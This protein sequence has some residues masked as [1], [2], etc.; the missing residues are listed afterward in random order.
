VASS[1]KPLASIWQG[2]GNLL[3]T[4][5]KVLATSWQLAGRFGK[6]LGWWVFGRFSTFLA[7]FLECR[8]QCA[9]F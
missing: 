1:G 6:L 8:K 5:G 7:R 3:A 9:E 2:C 4:S